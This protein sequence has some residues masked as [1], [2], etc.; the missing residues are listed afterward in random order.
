MNNIETVHICQ[1]YMV[2]QKWHHCFVRLN[3]SNINRF[4]KIFH[5]QNQEKI[6]NNTSSKDLTT[7][8]VCRL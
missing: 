7:L 4:S 8:Q 3:L 1:P 6:C 2:A 5:C